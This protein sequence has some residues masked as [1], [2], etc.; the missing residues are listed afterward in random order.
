MSDWKLERR[1]EFMSI[2]GDRDE[3]S[4]HVFT[5]DGY[6]SPP[7]QTF[8]GRFEGDCAEKILSVLNSGQYTVGP[9]NRSDCG[10]YGNPY[11]LIDIEHNGEKFSMMGTGTNDEGMESFHSQLSN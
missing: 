3:H 1:E 10:S 4:L 5:R 9:L 6:R 8:F 2:M 7:F 11:L